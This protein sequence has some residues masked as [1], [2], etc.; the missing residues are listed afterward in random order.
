[1]IAAA[2]PDRV[3]AALSDP[4]RLHLLERLEEGSARTATELAK[5]LP[6]SRQAVAKHLAE[7]VGAGLVVSARRGRETR[8]EL[9]PAGLTAATRWLDKRAA[10]WQQRLEALVRHVED[11]AGGGRRPAAGTR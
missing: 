9:V 6:M 8:Y 4:T 2:A 10:R 7:L 1:M 11:D 5:D 3:F